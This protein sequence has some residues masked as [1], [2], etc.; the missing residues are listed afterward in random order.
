MGIAMAVDPTPTP[1]AVFEL[2]E[3]A[4]DFVRRTVGIALDYT[5]ETLPI[6]DHYLGAVPHDQPATIELVATTAGAYFGEV[7]R[8]SLGGEWRGL[9]DVPAA[10]R[11]VLSGDVTFAPIDFAI[12]AIAKSEVEGRDGS[13]EVPPP[14]RELVEDALS[15]VGTVSNEEFF[16]LS[17]RLE[18]LTTVVNVVI[19]ARAGAG[20]TRS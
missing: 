11:V 2:A 9:E 19:G 6:L 5:P 14:E 7:A 4:V 17:G 13:F 16:S 10:W 1:S 3:K 20:A 18:T 8:K 15:A 12:E